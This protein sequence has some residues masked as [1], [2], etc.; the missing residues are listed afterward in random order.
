MSYNVVDIYHEKM[1]PVGEC[2]CEDRSKKILLWLS[3]FHLFPIAQSPLPGI[4]GL[5]L[6]LSSSFKQNECQH[7]IA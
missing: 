3:I 6:E 5:F 2:I 4:Q 7:G 1:P